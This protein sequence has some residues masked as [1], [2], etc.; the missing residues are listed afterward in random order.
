MIDGIQRIKDSWAEA[1]VFPGKSAQ[2]DDAFLIGDRRD[3]VDDLGRWLGTQEQ[4]EDI[5]GLLPA[6]APKGACGCLS[7]VRMKIVEKLE[8]GLRNRRWRPAANAS[9]GGRTH[10]GTVVTQKCEQSP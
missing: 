7:G 6:H 2:L 9:A 5:P 10:L 3:G 8:Q 4:S 1:C